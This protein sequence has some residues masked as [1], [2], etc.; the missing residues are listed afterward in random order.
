MYCNSFHC[1]MSEHSCWASQVLATSAVYAVLG[2]DEAVFDLTEQEISRMMICGTCPDS[3]VDKVQAKVAFRKAITVIADWITEY[4]EWGNDPELSEIR[5]KKREREYRV[6][7][8]GE[9]KTREKRRRVDS[10]IK[11]LKQLTREV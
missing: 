6:T 11:K 8:A 1:S 2:D 9:I 3:G 4:D 10:R 7:H 5:K